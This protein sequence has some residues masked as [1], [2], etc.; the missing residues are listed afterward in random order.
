MQIFRRL[1]TDDPATQH[2]PAAPGV[3]TPPASS[4]IIPTPPTFC[5][6]GLKKVL[7]EAEILLS[8]IQNVLSDPKMDF[9]QITSLI[10][11]FSQ[12]FVEIFNCDRLFLL[13]GSSHPPLPVI[14]ADGRTQISRP[15]PGTR[16][17]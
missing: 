5:Y 16:F 17:P 9:C 10:P 4:P 15:T 1:R 12:N 7:S 13:L 3:P 14:Y 6:P 2:H 8:G 11:I